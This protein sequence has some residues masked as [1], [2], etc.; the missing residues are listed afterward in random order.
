MD[1]LW[2][3]WRMAYIKGEPEPKCIFCD[4]SESEQDTHRQVLF[5]GRHAF[6][7]MNRFPYTNGH[8]M[9]APYRHSADLAAFKHDEVIDMHRLVCMA[10]DALVRVS[11]PDGF[12]IGLNIGRAA[13]AGITDHLHYHIVPRWN[14]DTNFMPVFADV[15]VVP[16]HLEETYQLLRQAFQDLAAEAK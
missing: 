15:R 9:V 14:G 4:H 12:N 3:P 6:A 5:R 1:C 8:M 11:R 10:R 7:L 13:G 2:A 16:Q